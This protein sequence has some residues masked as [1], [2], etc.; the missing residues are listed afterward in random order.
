MRWYHRLRVTS[1][2]WEQRARLAVSEDPEQRMEPERHRARR[3]EGHPV[4]DLVRRLGISLHMDFY[5]GDATVIAQRL[6]SLELDPLREGREAI[7]WAD[8]SLQLL[9]E[10]LELPMEIA[11]R[12]EGCDLVPFESSLG[13]KIAGDG[14]ECA[15]YKASTRCASILG[16]LPS[17]QVDQLAKEWLTTMARARGEGAADAT[18]GCVK[19]LLGL[20]QLCKLAVEKQA[21]VVYLWYL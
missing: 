7:A 18:P 16:G 15:A 6:D 21:D 17:G 4:P 19:A 2:D 10:D 5:A 3:P 14:K 12:L 20:I 8:F 13:R 9:P 1:W 11:C